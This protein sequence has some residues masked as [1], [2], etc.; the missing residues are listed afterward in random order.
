MEI[1]FISLIKNAY[2]HIKY[3]R[4][5][6]KAMQEDKVEEGLGKLFEGVTF[7][8]DWGGRVYAVLNPFI[9]NGKY[10]PTAVVVDEQ[11]G[12]WEAWMEDWVMQRLVAAQA[13]IRANNLFELLTYDLRQIDDSGNWLLVLSPI[14]LQP[15][16]RSLR[17]SAWTLLGIGAVAGAVLGGLAIFQ[18]TV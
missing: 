12:S 7:R 8:R 1:P 5:L 3:S 11:T 14:T 4:I 9:V 2:L 6:R 10:D 18:P 13:F 15:L 17:V 16:L